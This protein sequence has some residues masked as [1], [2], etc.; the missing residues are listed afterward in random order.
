MMKRILLRAI[1]V[2]VLCLPGLQK[3]LAQPYRYL[4]ADDFRGYPRANT[5]VVAYTNCTIDFHYEATHTGDYYTLNFDIKL[6]MN[7]N[8]SWMDK[9]RVTTPEM[10]AE[11]L[12]H[13]QGHY[14]IAYLEQQELLRT[15]GKTRFGANYEYAAADIFNSIDATYKQLDFDYDQD[16]QHMVNRVQQSS[17]DTYFKKRLLYMPTES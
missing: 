13:E 14:T 15:V 12:K 11:I 16:T 5:G 6:I 4:T 17:W 1:C 8:R 2:I 7:R 9:S 3:A 10:L